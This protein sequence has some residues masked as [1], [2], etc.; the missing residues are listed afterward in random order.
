[1]RED[2]RQAA[3][4][5]N[6]RLTV[7]QDLTWALINSPG[8]LVQS[9]RES[10]YDQNYRRNLQRS[11]RSAHEDDAARLAAHRRRRHARPVA[12][13]AAEAA[14]AWRRGR[15]VGGGPGWGKAKNIVMVYLQGGP[16]HLD[17]WDPKENV[18]DKIR[19][20]FK[21]IST[22]I[23]GVNFTEI[24]PELAKVNDKFTMIRS[25]SYT[26][27]GLFNHTAAI[28]QIMTGYTTDKVS[29]SGQLEPPDPKD[30]PNFGSQHHPPAARR[31]SRCC[32]SSCCRARCRNRNVIGKG[33]TAGFLGKAYDPYTLYPEGDDMDMDE[34]G[35][36][37]GRR[38]QAAARSLRVRLQAPRQAARSHR[39]SD[40]GHREGRGE[41]QPRRILPARA[42]PH[43]L[44]AGP[45]MPSI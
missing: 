40:A 41:L 1:M 21:P 10:I 37:Q 30:F 28:Y 12:R 25:M 32:R 35:P 22:K 7:V 6:K 44:A 17:L 27:N 9:L 3:N 18:P 14:G 19:S 39:A 4:N 2:G 34:D 5:E 31:P 16:S 43:R 8:I 33:G 13:L 36:H 29:P 15:P 24:L 42:E 45:A 38:S 26:P 11:L 23:P 20:A